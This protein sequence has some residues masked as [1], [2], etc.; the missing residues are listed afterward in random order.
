MWCGAA[1]GVV[2]SGELSSCQ[3]SLE[4]VE[5]FVDFVDGRLLASH[6]HWGPRD[7]YTYGSNTHEHLNQ[8]LSMMPLSSCLRSLSAVYGCV[9]GNCR[10]ASE[11][12]L[13]AVGGG[14]GQRVH[15]RRHVRLYVASDDGATLHCIDGDTEVSTRHKTRHACLRCLR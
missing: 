13:A 7:L 15:S 14:Q 1:L 12:V 11:L 10:A 8:S 5:A 9:Y 2:V 4:E 3:Q 6:A